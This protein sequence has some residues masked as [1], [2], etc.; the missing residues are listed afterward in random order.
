MTER[1]NPDDKKSKNKT[2]LH[3]IPCPNQSLL[4]TNPHS[5]DNNTT[6]PYTQA[7]WARTDVKKKPSLN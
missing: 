1:T 4:L 2:H 6:R 7:Q 3:W 5:T